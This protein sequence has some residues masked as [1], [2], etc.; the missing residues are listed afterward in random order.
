MIV[1]A[2]SGFTLATSTSEKPAVTTIW[3]AVDE[4]DTGGGAAA[5]RL[6][7]D[8]V[9]D[10]DRPGHRC[11]EVGAE[12][13]DA[14]VEEIGLRLR[15]RSLRGVERGPL[16]L[17]GQAGLLDRGAVVGVGGD[18]VVVGGVGLV[19]VER[20][21][22]EGG[23]RGRHRGLGG[24][25]RGIGGRR[26]DLGQQ[27]ARGH[28]VADGDRDVRDPAGGRERQVL[29]GGGVD[30]AGGGHG[31]GHLPDDGGRRAH[32]GVGGG[33]VVEQ[34]EDADR[35]TDDEHDEQDVDPRGGMS[36]ECGHGGRFHRGCL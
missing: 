36:T 6:A 30:G 35:G 22:V 29:R 11:V 1:A 19:T 15:Q 12:P 8:A 24:G 32:G 9:H 28:L 17:A 7:D 4:R 21:L 14:G 3:S 13:G 34:D 18:R 33:V 25:D 20:G 2:W 10:G 23:L 16:G 31:R 27:L 5:A 26:V